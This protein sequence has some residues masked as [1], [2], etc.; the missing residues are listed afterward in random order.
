[1]KE[2]ISVI[3]NVYNGEKF[4]KKCLDSVV[5][6]TYRNL[7]IIIINDGSTDNT[8]SICESYKDG[9]I[10]IITTENFGLSKSRNI[11]IDNSH[12]E[13]IYFVDSDDCI[14]LDTL[15]YLYNLCKKYKTKIATCK[16]LDIYN[17][18]F[19]EKNYKQRIKILSNKEMLE[20]ILLWDNRAEALW[21]KLIKKE[22]FNNLRFEDRPINDIAFTYK[23]ALTTEKIAYSNQIKYFYFKHNNN[24]RKQ[25]KEDLIRSIDL[26]NVSIERY[27]H[28]KKIYPNFKE[29]EFGVLF[30]IARLYLRKNKEIIDFLNKQSAVE[31]Y[32]KLFSI[33]ILGCK[34]LNV[35]ERIKLVLFRI[36]SKLYVWSINFYLKIKRKVV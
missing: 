7:E 14:E 17:Y 34:T 9:R 22:L 30:I 29:N 1:M 3:I 15:Q 19:I 23:L 25:K 28:I 2:L 5:N 24:K 20:K 12:G 21:N 35:R 27:E 31:L 6:Q 10:K 16:S 4:I 33:K 13:Y 11:G 18:K 26:Y 8:L 32:K 36:N